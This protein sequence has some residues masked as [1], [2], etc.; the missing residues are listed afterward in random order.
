M[1]SVIAQMP[2]FQASRLRIQANDK[3]VVFHHS[4]GGIL[5]ALSGF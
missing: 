5:S 1:A 4:S 3:A 2:A